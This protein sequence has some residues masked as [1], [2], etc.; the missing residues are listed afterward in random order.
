MSAWHSGASFCEGDAEALML[1]LM[2]AHNFLPLDA[3][4]VS[5]VGY[6]GVLYVVWTQAQA[7]QALREIAEAG[8]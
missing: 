7:I 5:Y 1:L 8:L 2:S 3:P 4:L 6:E